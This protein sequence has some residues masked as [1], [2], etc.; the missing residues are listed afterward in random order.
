LVDALIFLLVL[1]IFLLAMQRINILDVGSGNASAKDGDSLVLNGTEVRLHGIDAP[2]YNQS[3]RSPSGDY[4][5]GREA[6]EALRALL[7]GRII[8]CNSFETD[9]YGRAVSECRNGNININREMVMQGWAV[10]YLR[11]STAFVSAQREAKLAK[12]GLW[13]GT[14]E[15]PEDYRSRTRPITGDAS[16]ASPPED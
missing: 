16:G 4:P 15:M 12:R 2:E 8:Q 3:C 5:C 13:Q 11:H 6:R 1:T 9:R 14:F 7:R 10:A